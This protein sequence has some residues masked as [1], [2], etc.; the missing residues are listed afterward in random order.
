[1]EQQDK[2]IKEF[3]IKPG[4]IVFDHYKVLKQIGKGGMDSIVY[5]VEDIAAPKN[6]FSLNYYALKIIN[7]TKD[8]TDES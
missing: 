1:M 3:N 6:S 7:R 5:L 4:D 8:T 2:E